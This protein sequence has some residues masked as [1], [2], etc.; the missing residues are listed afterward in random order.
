MS[1]TVSTILAYAENKTQAGTG[2]IN[3]TTLG[4]PF[5][6]DAVVDYRKDLIKRNIDAGQISEAYATPS[7]PPTGQGS[8][9]AFPTDY[10]FLKTIEVNMTDGQQQDYIQ[11][12]PLDAANTPAGTS[13]DWLRVNQDPNNPMFD[14][15]GNVFE[16]FPSFA[17]ATNFNNALKILY[18]VQPTVYVNLSDSIVYPDTLDWQAL[19]TRV[20]SLY[21][22][23]LNKFTEA[24][25]WEKKYGA[26]IENIIV[27][28]AQGS[29]QQLQPQGLVGGASNDVNGWCL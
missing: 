21:Y 18:F 22:Q 24:D 23:S 15:R 14:D 2:T 13:Y 8:V 16:I 6:N 29:K 3:N 28:Q 26:R 1:T 4:V 27:T 10:F 11:A 19:G 12:Q 9:F 5:L 20:A 25:Y 7:A 17:H